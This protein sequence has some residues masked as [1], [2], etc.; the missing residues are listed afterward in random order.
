M[1]TTKTL[2]VPATIKVGM[3]VAV[4]L[5]R[6][7]DAWKHCLGSISGATDAANGPVKQ[8]RPAIIVLK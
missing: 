4:V 5:K 6:V 7:V 2:K 8:L 3:K 1:R